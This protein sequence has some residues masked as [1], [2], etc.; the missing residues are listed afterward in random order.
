MKSNKQRTGSFTTSALFL[1]ASM[2]ALNA[3]AAP[4]PFDPTGYT[5]DMSGFLK[6][7]GKARCGGFAGGGGAKSKVPLGAS[8][9][10]GEDDTF[11]WFNDSMALADSEGQVMSRSK[12]GRK[13][14][15]AFNG[16]QAATALFQMAAIPNNGNPTGMDIATSYSLNA[17]V[18]NKKAKV[19]EKAV[20]RYTIA[21]SP[22]YSCNYKYTITR[23]MTGVPPALSL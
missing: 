13:L 4:A 21:V 23:T 2:L 1:V 9:S 19:V 20:Y 3:G 17:T 16:E 15:L 7:S 18:S 10:F 11:L 6:V 12:N 8:I 22:A 5:Y 14:R